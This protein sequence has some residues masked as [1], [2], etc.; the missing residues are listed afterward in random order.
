MDYITELG[1]KLQNSSG[2]PGNFI[3]M[4]K[5]YLHGIESTDKYDL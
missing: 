2:K 1:K 3:Q 5:N 4:N